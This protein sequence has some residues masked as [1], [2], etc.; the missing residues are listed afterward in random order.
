MNY[1]EAAQAIISDKRGAQDSVKENMLMLYY[2]LKANGFKCNADGRAFISACMPKL[3]PRNFDEEYWRPAVEYAEEIGGCK[4]GEIYEYPNA[5]GTTSIAKV[6]SLYDLP[7]D[8]VNPY[9]V[10]FSGMMTAHL[11]AM[12]AIRFYAKKHKRLLPFL[13]IGKSGNKGLYEAVFNRESGIVTEAEYRAYINAMK[14]MAPEEYVTKDEKV[15]NDID[16]AGNFY[17]LYRFAKEKGLEEITL[18]LCSGN[19]SYDK[20]LLAEG[21][22]LLKKPEFADV[23]INLVL[24]HCPVFMSSHVPEGH[25]SEIMLGYIAA[26][27]GPLMKDTVPFGSEAKGER[28]LM[29]GVTDADWD[30]FK[31]LI[32]FYSNMGWPDY[33][34]ILYGIDH[35]TAVANVILSD[36]LAKASFTAEEYDEGICQD[37]EDYQKL[38]GKY[39]DGED[40][41]T[42]L[43][44]TPDE[45]YF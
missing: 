11:Y 7:G 38:I 30:V 17:E 5:Q 35:E 15:F 43:Q 4:P 41:L 13:A 27:L 9:L 1:F 31:E 45:K 37:I 44:N 42:Y 8:M 12:E 29:P 10:C 16:T 20:R 2:L 21:M 3:G 6:Y 18:I 39:Q 22:L 25:V 19:F 36:L 34:E 32:C 24:V 28:Y 26:S 40:F 14:L 33:Q 23:K